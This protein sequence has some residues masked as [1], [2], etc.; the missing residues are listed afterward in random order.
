M[1]MLK[2]IFVTVICSIG[3]TGL[4][5]QDIHLTSGNKTNIIEAGTFIEVMMPPDQETEIECSRN[6]V[7]GEFIS[8]S[9]G[10]L[11]MRVLESLEPLMLEKELAGYTIKKYKSKENKLII[12]IPNENILSITQKGKKKLRDNATMDVIGVS[13]ILLGSAHLISAPIVRETTEGRARTLYGLG[14]AEVI[15]GILFVGIFSQKMYITS[16]Y[17]PDK[18]PGA[19]VWMLN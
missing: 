18:K 2:S 19:K 17:C 16:E 7:L 3:I 14:L 12:D 5:A 10:K 8:Y 11:K 4:S 1:R 15:T 13:L 6:K 9:E